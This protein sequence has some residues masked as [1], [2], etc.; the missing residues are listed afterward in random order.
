MNI[1]KTEKPPSKEIRIVSIAPSKPNHLDPSTISKIKS[2]QSDKTTSHI[3]NLVEGSGKAGVT[4]HKGTGE[5]SYMKEYFSKS[6]DLLQ[7]LQP[8]QEYRPPIVNF[9]S[10]EAIN[11]PELSFRLYKNDIKLVRNVLESAGF[12]Q[13]ENHDW[14]LLW[15]TS[16]PKPYLYD[17]LNPYQKISHF[18]NSIEITRKDRLTAVIKKMQN[19]F[20]EKHFDFMPETFVMPEEFSG[21]YESFQKNNCMWIVKPASSS[22]GK[23]IYLVDSLGEIPIDE[24]CIISKYL[25]DPLTINGLKFDLRLYVVVTSYEP[26]RIYVF[27]EGLVRFSSEAYQKGCKNNRYMHLTNYSLNKKNEGYVQNE[28]F[29]IDDSGHKWSLSALCKLLE[30]QGLNTEDMWGSIYDLIIKT[31][32][33]GEKAVIETCKSIGMHRNNCFDLLGFDVLLD[34]N[35]KPWLLEV[36]LSPSLATDSPLDKYIKSSLL[37]DMLHLVGIRAFE[38]RKRSNSK[39]NYLRRQNNLVSHSTTQKKRDSFQSRYRDMVRETLEEQERR[40]NFLRIFPSKGTNY[41]DQ[42]FLQQRNFNKFVY[43]SIYVELMKEAPASPSYISLPPNRPT[44]SSS[45]SDSP[46]KPRDLT[47]PP[48]LPPKSS[49]LFSKVQKSFMEVSEKQVSEKPKDSKKRA[50][51]KIVITGDDIIMEYLERLINLLQSL[52][53]KMLLSRW[54]RSLEKFIGHYVWVSTR[55]TNGKLWMRL[56]SRLIEMRERRKKLIL[57]MKRS[58]HLDLKDEKKASYLKGLSAEQLENLMKT[59]TKNVA[60]DVVNCL[61]YEDNKGVLSE[62]Q[63]IQESTSELDSPSFEGEEENVNS[64]KTLSPVL[65]KRHFKPSQEKLY[66][67]TFN[68]QF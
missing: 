43:N 17:R 57:S 59:S 24:E 67:R 55:K 18:P 19:L 36:N 15:V 29:R 47:C 35:L 46:G 33:S 56:Q 12:T 66:R 11:L 22:Q 34:T 51:E 3:K 10:R 48:I 27:K 25:D 62:I 1:D 7:E 52:S 68:K 4:L 54:K 21:F 63:N 41:Y 39:T 65:Q 23:G 13:T 9:H 16:A 60:L 42:F 50:S 30:S 32:I 53:E 2:Q 58:R 20:G 40:G 28:D 64:R 61:L 37:T 6:R 26:L 49:K 8:T 14:N 45:S 38:R 31:I 44:T 5:T